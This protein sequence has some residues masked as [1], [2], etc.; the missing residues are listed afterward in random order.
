MWLSCHYHR[1]EALRL[2]AVSCQKYIC[3][4]LLAAPA[5]GTEESLVAA[6]STV[7]CGEGHGDHAAMYACPAASSCGT[8]VVL[9]DLG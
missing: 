9:L 4:V 5:Q 6:S 8:C 1:E 7:E 3:F 2:G